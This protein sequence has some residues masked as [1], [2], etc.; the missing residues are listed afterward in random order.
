[1]SLLNSSHFIH[2]AWMCL[3]S[4]AWKKKRTCRLGQICTCSANTITYPTTN[5]IK[6]NEFTEMK[7]YNYNLTAWMLR[8][9]TLE[10]SRVHFLGN[11]RKN[12]SCVWMQCK[13]LPYVKVNITDLS[14]VSADWLKNNQDVERPRVLCQ[15]R[16]EI[17]GNATRYY[18]LP[19][20]IQGFPITL[21][22]CR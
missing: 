4:M 3:S 8:I 15:L 9:H 21:S 6:I 2:T 5:I 10:R 22:A 20:H 1:M 14:Y 16:I 11:W 17:N 19:W 18:R 13:R 12:W 7:L